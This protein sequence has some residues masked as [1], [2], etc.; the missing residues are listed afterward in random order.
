MPVWFGGMSVAERDAI[1]HR[2]EQVRKID[3]F[4]IALDQTALRRILLFDQT[5]WLPDNLLER[6]DRMMMAGSIEGR[7]PFMDVEL[8]QLAAR[9]PDR[10]QI[11]R[12]QGKA[13]MRLALARILPKPIINRK[14]MGFPVPVADWFRHAHRDLLRDLLCSRESEARSLCRPAM[15]DRLVDEHLQGKQN[16]EKVLWA[17]ANLELFVGTFKREMADRWKPRF[18]MQGTSTANWQAAKVF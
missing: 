10:F 18:A 11:R 15:L 17:L 4:A 5:S 8:A 3:P 6:G 2:S 14:K 7:M 16:H 9:L 1:M 13:V 12:L